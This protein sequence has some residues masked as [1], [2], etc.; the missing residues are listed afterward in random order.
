MN[1]HLYLAHAQ[2]V[3]YANNNDAFIPELWAME[4][5]SVLAENM[6]VASLVNR[7][8][9]NDVQKYGD[10]VNT[11]KVAKGKV[12]RKTGTDTYDARD[13]SAQNIPVKLDQ[14]YFDSIVI[15]D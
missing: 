6:V 1:L 8:F 15:K 14:L 2:V 11:Q 12:R 3:C 4:G 7:D 5:V 10:V 9:S 13:V